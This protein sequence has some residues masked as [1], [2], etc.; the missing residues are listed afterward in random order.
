MPA[1][2]ERP[3]R[4]VAR[5]PAA[6]FVLWRARDIPEH[7]LRRGDVVKLVDY[8]RSPN[9]ENGYSIEVFKPESIRS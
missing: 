9:G 6:P 5:I 4:R 1:T 2:P 7:R 3:R 8:H